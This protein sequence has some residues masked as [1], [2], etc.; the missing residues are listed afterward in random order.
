MFLIVTKEKKIN[1]FLSLEKLR[2]KMFGEARYSRVFLTFLRLWPAWWRR[3]GGSGRREEGR[4]GACLGLAFLVH[5]L[6]NNHHDI[7]LS[8]Y[9]S[10][11]LSIGLHLQ[12]R[13]NCLWCINV[14]THLENRK[15]YVVKFR[16]GCSSWPWF[17]LRHFWCYL[18]FKPPDYF[19]RALC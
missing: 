14:Q 9:L 16:D 3:E 10:M 1:S 5:Y 8:N 4:R 11:Y 17:V 7:C 6:P 15:P 18:D 13:R 12:N 2:K 19:R